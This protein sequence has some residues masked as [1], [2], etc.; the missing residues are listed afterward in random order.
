MPDWQPVVCKVDL[1]QCA[2]YKQYKKYA[3]IRR[4]IVFY[5]ALHVS[6]SLIILMFI[7]LRVGQ[8]LPKVK[9]KTRKDMD[10][11][12]PLKHKEAISYNKSHIER[13]VH[14]SGMYCTRGSWSFQ[15]GKTGCGTRTRDAEWPTNLLLYVIQ[16]SLWISRIL[17][18]QQRFA[19]WL[20]IACWVADISSAMYDFT[21]FETT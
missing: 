20:W 21:V 13:S 9:N 7:S 12:I 18:L 2:R 14:I 1:A 4:F 16:H 11:N 17:S 10:R 5:Y 3:H 19:A 15:K 6:I 8:I